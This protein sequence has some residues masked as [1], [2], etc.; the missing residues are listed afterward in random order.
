MI[1]NR[2]FDRA[3]LAAAVKD[4]RPIIRWTEIKVAGPAG[5]PNTL[6]ILEDNRI[7]VQRRQLQLRLR[8]GQYGEKA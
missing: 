8:S 6:P 4:I 5:R 2:G 1:L 3:A 7:G